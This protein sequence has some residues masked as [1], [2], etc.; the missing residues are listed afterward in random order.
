MPIVLERI[1]FREKFINIC[2]HEKMALGFTEIGFNLQDLSDYFPGIQLKQLK[3]IHSNRIFRSGRIRP[4]SRGDG[5]ILDARN[6]IAIIKTADCVPL[7][8]WNRD[9]TCGGII[10]IG[11][12][13]LQKKIERILLKKL[14]QYGF[15]PADF[16]F[17]MGP[18]IEKS[19]Y[20]VNRD[21]FERF[22]GYSYQERVFPALGGGRYTLDIKAAIRLSLTQTGISGRG[23]IMDAN[24][25]TYCTADRFPS[26]RRDQ[27]VKDRILNFLV[28]F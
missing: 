17:F 11:W 2:R 18:C 15:D 27:G 14:R 1:K 6:T 24:V 13:G 10:H 9:Y 28:L 12:K 16:R 8:F 26:Y 4:V 21:V 5:I 25:C 23:K 22:E 19:C 7:F 3:Q 20:P